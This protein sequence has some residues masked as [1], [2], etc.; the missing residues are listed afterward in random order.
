MKY[1]ND[2]I[3]CQFCSQTYSN[4]DGIPVGAR[5]SAPVQTGPGAYPT[6][7][8]MGTGSSPELERPLCG[9]NHPPP[10]SATLKNEYGHTSTPIWNFVA[11]SRVNFTITIILNSRLFRSTPL[12]VT[13]LH[14]VGFCIVWANFRRLHP[15]L[16]QMQLRTVGYSPGL[17]LR[18]TCFM[19]AL[20]LFLIKNK[21]VS[22]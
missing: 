6:S 4:W 17:Y 14:Y 1:V 19:G 10:S 2:T 11:F 15:Y 20:K 16:P 21:F 3:Y 18:S 8:A 5:F 9:V 7:Y 12:S 13:F 22:T